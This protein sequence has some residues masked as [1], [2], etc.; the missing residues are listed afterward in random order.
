MPYC[1]NCGKELP[2]GATFC[3]NCGVPVA[4]AAPSQVT[5][6]KEE[7]EKVRPVGI[8]IISILQAI[9]SLFMLIGGIALIGLAAFLSVG[10]WGVVSEVELEMALREVPWASG[11]TAVPLMALTTTFLTV[12][13]IIVLAI[14]VI[15]FVLAWGLWGG[16]RWA[17][18]A[19]LVLSALGILANLFS[20]PVSIIGILIYAAIVY[21]LTRS[22]VKAYY[23]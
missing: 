13:G 15:G 8:G 17:W 10:G 3:P 5:E 21:Y 1:K 12:I 23:Q 6:K 7:Q 4:A 11:F 16:K 9:V 14:A 22:Y 19:T 2:E 20:L 18:A